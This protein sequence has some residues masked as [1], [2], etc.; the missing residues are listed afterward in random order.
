LTRIVKNFFYITGLIILFTSCASRKPLV[1]PGSSSVP[2]PKGVDRKGGTLQT[3][4]ISLTSE[5]SDEAKV[6]KPVAI[7]PR[8][9][10]PGM[11]YSAEI[12]ACDPLQ[13][14]YSI[15]LGKPVEE[16]DNA[17]LVAFMESWYGIPYKYGGDTSNGIDCSAFTCLMMDTVYNVTIPRTAKSQYNAS[18]KIRKQ[19]LKEGDLVF[20]NTTG[21]ISHVGVYL[22]N[23]RFIHAAASNGVMISSLEEAYFKKRYIGAARVR[24]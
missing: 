6:D 13:F 17:R 14:K 11:H 19:D 20:F 2:P 4:N 9:T 22:A 7:R 23:D 5:S 15:L 1:Y 18:T 21:G 8:R 16:I 12:E 10:M 3:E 24:Q